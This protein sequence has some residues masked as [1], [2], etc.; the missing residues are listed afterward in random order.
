[1]RL[2]LTKTVRG[3][4]KMLGFASRLEQMSISNNPLA[5]FIKGEFLKSPLIKGDSGGCLIAML[6]TL[7]FLYIKFKI[8]SLRPLWL[9]VFKTCVL[10]VNPVKIRIARPRYAPK[11]HFL[12]YHR[13]CIATG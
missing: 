8:F 11:Y 9:A 6:R 3:I 10:H 2:P 7:K 12:R 4:Q 13:N 5:P 1:M